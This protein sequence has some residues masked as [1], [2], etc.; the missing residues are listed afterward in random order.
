MQPYLHW[1]V[2]RA[3][4]GEYDGSLQVGYFTGI[5][6]FYPESRVKMRLMPFSAAAAMIIS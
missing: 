4:S 3:Q 2:D 1:M 6:A 5:W